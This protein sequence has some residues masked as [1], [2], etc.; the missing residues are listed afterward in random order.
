ML[1]K[2]D[3]NARPLEL[4]KP[5]KLHDLHD[6]TDFDC[7][8]DSINEFLHKKARKAQEEK[9][10]VVYVVC[11]EGSYRV[12]AFYTLSSGSVPRAQVVPKALQ[13]NSPAQHPVTILGRMGVTLTAQGRGL[14]R[15]LIKDAVIKVIASSD[16]VATS[17]VLVHPLNE[18]LADMYEKAGFM[19]CP[20]ISP[21]S[22]ML[23][24]R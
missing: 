8:E 15:A 6:F 3:V 1:T 7:G 23:S 19:A 17:A 24:L 10:S 12:A 20:D 14:S 4:K 13:R 22:M 21:L 16:M 5:E 2:T 11:F 9:H 18:R